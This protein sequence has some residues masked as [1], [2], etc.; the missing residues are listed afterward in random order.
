MI[1]EFGVAQIHWFA[2]YLKTQAVFFLPD[3]MRLILEPWLRAHVDV[4]Q[5]LSSMNAKVIFPSDV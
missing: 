5:K 3:Q 1:R 4:A 2:H